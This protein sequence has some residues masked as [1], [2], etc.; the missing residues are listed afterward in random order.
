MFAENIMKIWK[1]QISKAKDEGKELPP[2]VLQ[3]MEMLGEKDGYDQSQILIIRAFAVENGFDGKLF[4]PIL[5][6]TKYDNIS[7]F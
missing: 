7:L 6:K 2:S 4:Q 1:D 5:E 3:M